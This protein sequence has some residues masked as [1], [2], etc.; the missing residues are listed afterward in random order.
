[1]ITEQ[2][3]TLLEQCAALRPKRELSM[4]ERGA[5]GIATLQSTHCGN[6]WHR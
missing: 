5:K 6:C 4:V 3:S 2:E 1:M